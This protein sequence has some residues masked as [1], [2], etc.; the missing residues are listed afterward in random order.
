[1]PW[2]EWPIF[3]ECAGTLT[4]GFLAAFAAMPSRLMS[5]ANVA[6]SSGHGKMY[7]DAYSV[8]TGVSLS[9]RSNFGARE[10]PASNAVNTIAM[11]RIIAVSF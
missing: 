6:A 4:R 8:V 11:L 5:Q 10:Q 9:G 7:G 2:R 3:Q 1:M